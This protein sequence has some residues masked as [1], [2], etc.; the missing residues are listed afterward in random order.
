MKNIVKLATPDEIHAYVMSLWSDGLI[1]K[2]HQEG[3]IVF[4]VIEKFA[5]MPRI[6]FDASDSKIE[7][8]HFS[9]WWGAIVHAEYDNPVIRDLRY[10]HE[11]Y[12]G[13]TFPYSDGLSVEEMR[14]RN[15]Q[16]EREASVFTEIAIY[17]AIPELRAQ[18][19]DHPIFADQIINDAEW[20]ARW[21][22]DR[23]QT[24]A[25]LIEYRAKAV[26]GIKDTSDPQLI[27]LQRYRKQEQ[28]WVDIWRMN[29]NRVDQHM[30]SL[31]NNPNKREAINAHIAWLSNESTHGVPFYVEAVSF[32]AAYDELLA[33]YN[34][35]MAKAGEKPVAYQKSV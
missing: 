13:A 33:A 6:F 10:L 18:S 26:D 30:V 7:W 1:K 31:R 12:H 14:Q 20:Q 22:N 19:F 3:G 17:L 28:R 4:D 25:D 23:Q 9:T 11:I 21:E 32:R 8:T 15:F 24:I 29:Y 35:A 34:E 27:W 2:S 16:N 5:Q